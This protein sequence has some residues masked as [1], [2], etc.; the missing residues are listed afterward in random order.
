M[1][2]SVAADGTLALEVKSVAL[3]LRDPDGGVH[4]AVAPRPAPV[5]TPAV[6]VLESLRGTAVRVRLN[7]EKGVTDVLGIDAAWARAKASLGAEVAALAPLA[8]DSAWARDLANAGMSQVPT[9]LQPAAAVVRTGRVRVA[10]L[11]VSE[12]RLTGEA[13][14]DD[15]GSPAVHAAARLAADAAFVGDYGPE[16]PA[17]V[18]A[19]RI[20][21]VTCEATTSYAS[22]PPRPFK[23]EWT[24]TTPFAGGLTV[25]TTTSFTLVLR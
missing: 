20:D 10:G 24:V 7:S 14:R 11:G 22:D 19:A 18:G 21:E 8:S 2:G 9:T 12:V 17:G 13:A 15:R 1:E 25:R 6:P 4:R 23:G 16:P 5:E 3:E